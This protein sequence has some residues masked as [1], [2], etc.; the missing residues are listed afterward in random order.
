VSAAR[1]FSGSRW[2]VFADDVSPLARLNVPFD[3]ELLVAQWDGAVAHLSEMYRVSPEQPLKVLYYGEWGLGFRKNWPSG[4]L[5]RRRRSLE[6]RVIT[7]AFLEDVRLYKE[8][9]MP[10]EH[11][12]LVLL[13]VCRISVVSGFT[14]LLPNS[15]AYNS[16][17]D[18]SSCST[19]QE[20][21]RIS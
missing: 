3:C 4:G 8:T 16:S 2:L 21:P 5:Y 9:R 19:S 11:L 12:F 13:I 20:I 7:T 15:M 14:S 10:V 1:K 17:S 6:G 18:A